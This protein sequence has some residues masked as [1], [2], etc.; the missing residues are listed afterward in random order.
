MVHQ[1]KLSL[2][3]KT[4]KKKYQKVYIRTRTCMHDLARIERRMTIT[5]RMRRMWWADQ[6]SLN[7]NGVIMRQSTVINA[8]NGKC[9]A[10]FFP[11]R[12]RS[13]KWKVQVWCVWVGRLKKKRER[14]HGSSIRISKY[15]ILCAAKAFLLEAQKKF[16]RVFKG[17]TQRSSSQTQN[18]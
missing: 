14:W 15:S 10:S 3:H 18:I 7:G 16:V 11:E 2:V 9:E 1:A 6:F 8:S 13:I 5:I 4:E 17:Y 12:S